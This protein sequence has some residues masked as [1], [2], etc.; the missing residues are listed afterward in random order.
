MEHILRWSPGIGKYDVAIVNLF[1]CGLL[2]DLISDDNPISDVVIDFST[3]RIFC[4][5]GK[6]SGN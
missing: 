3:E 2:N 4:L 6:V 5:E 1:H